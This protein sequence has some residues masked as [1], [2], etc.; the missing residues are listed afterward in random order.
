MTFMQE[1][2][3]MLCLGDGVFACDVQLATIEQHLL[4]KTRSTE[5]RK[6]KQKRYNKLQQQNC[7][8]ISQCGDLSYISER[9][10]TLFRKK[11][12]GGLLSDGFM[13]VH[14]AL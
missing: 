12:S 2:C 11:N 1:H 4:I 8:F 9:M 7:Q 10:R 3:L 5:Y 13:S 6:V 14:Q